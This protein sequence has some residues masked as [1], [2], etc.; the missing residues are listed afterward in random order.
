MTIKNKQVEFS[1]ICHQCNGHCCHNARPPITRQR[2]EQ[3]ESYLNAR[4]ISI[5]NLFVEE[6]YVFPQEDADQFCI[7]HN[8]ST[9]K[10]QI[11]V[12][13]PETCVA[14]PIT[15]DINKSTQKIEWYLKT[16]K[17][18]PLAGALYKNNTALKSH[19]KSAKQEILRL[20]YDLSPKSL[21]AILK[22]TEPNTFKISE[23]VIDSV[24]VK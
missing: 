8:R 19:L 1:A 23:D 9:Q 2:R 15:F 24:I 21:Q 22:I 4:N 6:V 14:G 16:E 3:I 17:I 13:K 5:A 18:C 10:C 11:H 12:V 20:L 7:F